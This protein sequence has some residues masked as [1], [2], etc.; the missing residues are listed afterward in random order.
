MDTQ[1]DTGRDTGRQGQLLETALKVFARHG[2][3]KTSME[4]IAQAAQ[5]SRQG[6]YLHFKN[7]EDIFKASIRRAIDTNLSIATIAL[8]DKDSPL[9]DKLLHALDGWFGR[10]VGLFHIEANDISQYIRQFFG[11]A[12]DEWRASFRQQLVKVI[13]EEASQKI[14]VRQATEIAQI[15]C[16][17]GMTWKNELAS[18]DEFLSR[19]K[20]TI[21]ICCQNL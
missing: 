9:E 12:V 2:F 10:Y 4:D 7:K 8:N 16:A 11:D 15:L 21:R 3:K 14:T 17:C 20:A 13:T 18:R 5:I 1:K 6:L 19:M